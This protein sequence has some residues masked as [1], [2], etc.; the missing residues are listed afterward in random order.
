MFIETSL[1]KSWHSDVN[2][3]YHYVASLHRLF[4]SNIFTSNPK[5][6]F[7][8][9][10]V[11]YITWQQSLQLLLTIHL[12][13]LWDYLFKAIVTKGSKLLSSIRNIFGGDKSPCKSSKWLLN[14]LNPSVC[15]NHL[16][17]NPP[18]GMDDFIVPRSIFNLTPSSSH[19]F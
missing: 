14:L 16:S 1:D 12:L 4:K 19:T 11:A 18:S 15:G 6:R 7:D 10:F 5:K 2:S 17:D 3:R 8:R 9:F 13:K